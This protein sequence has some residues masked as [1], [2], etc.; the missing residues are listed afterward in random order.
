MQAAERSCSPAVATITGLALSSLLWAATPAYGAPPSEDSAVLIF[1]RV[2]PATVSLRATLPARPPLPDES[3]DMGAGFIIDESGLI[4][5]AAHVVE[6]ADRITA[7]L[8][9]G[10]RLEAALVGSDSGTDLAV[11]R[12]KGRQQRFPAV[13]LGDSDAVRVGQQAL[14]IG[15]PFG[16]GLTLSMGFVSGLPTLPVPGLPGPPGLIQM[17]VPINPGDSGGPVI[18]SRGRIVGIARAFLKQAQSIGFAIPINV[19]KGVL[20]DLIKNG[21][22]VRPWLG[23]RGKFVTPAIRSLFTLPLQPGL[24]IEELDMYSPASVAGLEA[25]G[26]RVTIEGEPWI[27]GGD[28]IVALN[29]KQLRFLGDFLEAVRTVQVGDVVQIDYLRG[30]RRYRTTAVIGERPSRPVDPTP[31]VPF[32]N[33]TGRAAAGHR[34]F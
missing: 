32:E 17:T 25:G 34:S 24:L 10:Q 21:R 30:G 13:R 19:A 4:L 12:L 27:L 2:A 7:T 29:G 8:Y 23:V 22:V 33:F 14:V 3:L 28:I 6:G 18:D 9:D 20:G 11:L 5:T 31:E 16:L 1:Q 26:L 15:S